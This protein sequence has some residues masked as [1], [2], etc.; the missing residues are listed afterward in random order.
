MV[1]SLLEC[2]SGCLATREL[3]ERGV[4]IAAHGIALVVI[5]PIPTPPLTTARGV[6]G[7]RGG[8]WG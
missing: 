5:S 6:R 4:D 7:V 3:E 1:S 2:A 8:G